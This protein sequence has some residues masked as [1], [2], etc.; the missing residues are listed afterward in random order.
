MPLDPARL[1]YYVHGLVSVDIWQASPAHDPLS[2]PDPEHAQLSLPLQAAA[3]RPAW[4]HAPEEWVLGGLLGMVAHR[5]PYLWPSLISARSC[6]LFKTLPHLQ[7]L[8]PSPSLSELPRDI[9]E[10]HSLRVG[11]PY[12]T[13]PVTRKLC[14]PLKN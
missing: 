8:L 5:C 4:G 11:S 6:L 10:T 2:L 3:H 13:S 12:A 9:W 7:C 14:S 1:L